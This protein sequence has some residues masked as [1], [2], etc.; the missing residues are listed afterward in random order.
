M[1]KQKKA[2]QNLVEI[3]RSFAYKL[4][5]PKKDKYDNA[6]TRE[7]FCSQKAEC[8][9]KDAEKI[10]EELHN[11]VKKSVINSVNEYKKEL[12]ASGQAKTTTTHKPKTWT[13]QKKEGE[14]HEAKLEIQK[15]EFEKGKIK[16]EEFLKR[17]EGESD[18][19]LV[20]V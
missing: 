6:E 10:S 2:K 1:K 17:E 19:G 11:F 7:F 13:E 9:E 12:I 15:E 3:A 8:N 5:L 14:E 4:V 18:L 20:K 16:M